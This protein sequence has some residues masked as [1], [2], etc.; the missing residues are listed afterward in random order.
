[1]GSTSDTITQARANYSCYWYEGHPRYPYDLNPTAGYDAKFAV[2][3]YPYTSPAGYFAANGYGL[4]DM[5]G[6]V[7]NWCWDWYD[8]FYYSSSPETDPRGSLSTTV[9]SRVSRGGSWY[10]YA[11]NARCAYR[12]VPGIKIFNSNCTG[13]RC[14]RGI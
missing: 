8:A 1:M 9:Y 7:E 14:V 13:F 12:K 4:Y 5:A 2:D 3:G 11:Y 10:G 6:N